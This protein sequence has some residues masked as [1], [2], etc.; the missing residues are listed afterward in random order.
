MKSLDMR[1]LGAMVLV[2][3][4]AAARTVSAEWEVYNRDGAKVVINADI[5]VAGFGNADSWFGE[6]E[7]FLGDETDAWLEFGFEPRL[8]AEMPVGGGTLYGQVS[9]VYTGT[10][11]E[12]A[13]GL[14]I[15][16]DSHDLRIEQGH[17]GW[18]KENLFEGL[19]DDT[20][21]LSIGRQDYSIGTGMIINDG[22]GDGGE[23]GG[24]YIGMRKAFQESIIMRLKSKTLLAE[25]FRLRN[26]PRQG[27]TQGEAYGGNLEYTF[28]EQVTFG[29]TYM[30]VN[31]ELAGVDTLDV[32][33]GRLDWKIGNGFSVSGEY[34]HEDSDEQDADGWYV[35]AAYETPD[36]P[37]SPVWSYQYAHFDGDDPDTTKDETFREIAYGFTD[38]GTWYQGEIN[39]NYPLANAN[40]QSHQVRVKATPLETL[41]VNLLYYHFTLDEPAAFGVTSDEWGD[42]IN[43]T[44]DW[45]ATEHLYVIGVVGVLMPGNAAEQY[46]G[47]N[48]D[49]L[50]SM[51]YASFAW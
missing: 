1:A 39:G 50:Y 26:R 3:S 15:G 42:E 22:G 4:L 48:D 14:T 34:V 8:S 5:V 20:F 28:A 45:Q 40:L 51:L 21:S 11:G 46:T 16:T 2:A 35:K 13:S 19:E 37:W 6:D 44:A 27:G 41:T 25:G 17:G 29:G 9:G 7:E 30:A 31:P 43:L 18:K 36:L 10:V 24:W 12:D 23:R 33:S 38:Y 47:G 32:F 49:W